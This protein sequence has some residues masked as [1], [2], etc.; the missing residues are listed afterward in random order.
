MLA[1][2]ADDESLATRLLGAGAAVDARNANGGTALMYA[3][4]GGAV[5]TGSLLIA[6]G[7]DVNARARFGWTALMV[8]AVK[9]QAQFCRLLLD[10]DAEVN[11]Q[12]TYGWT[13]LMRAASRNR[14][15]T[16]ALLLND[17]E[18]DPDIS[19]S[20]GATAL[21]IA[22]GLGLGSI[23]DTLISGGADPTILDGEG[24]TPEQV[25][26]LQGYTEIERSLGRA[27]ARAAQQ[28]R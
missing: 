19:Q 10:A 23:V 11:A 25:A 5:S 18:T 2:Q 22:A 6:S 12:D 27:A 20:S 15:T 26:A 8:A 9:G 28:V 14:Q 16:V 21:H 24:R 1:A 13:A 4:L 7:A 17:P 3:G